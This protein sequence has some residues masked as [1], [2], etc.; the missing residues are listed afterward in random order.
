MIRISSRER[1]NDRERSNRSIF[2][3]STRDDETES[4]QRFSNRKESKGKKNFASISFDGE[5]EPRYPARVVGRNVIKA[6][7]ITGRCGY[8]ASGVTTKTHAKALA[9]DRA[10]AVGCRTVESGE[11]E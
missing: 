1:N 6:K 11:A 4:W 5:V 7:Q 8:E 9:R 3:V 10:I 2:K